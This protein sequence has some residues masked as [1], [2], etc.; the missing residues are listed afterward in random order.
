MA[1]QQVRPI[2][3]HRHENAARNIDNIH[4]WTDALRSGMF[5]QGFRSLMP[6]PNTFCCLGLGSKLAGCEVVKHGDMFSIGGE[7]SMPPKEFG[8]WL[9]IPNPRG[10]DAHYY[11]DVRVGFAHDWTD[12]YGVRRKVGSLSSSVSDL[13]DNGMSFNEIADLIDQLGVYQ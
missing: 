8:E 9:G 1:L 6:A 12:K 4:R 7:V 5:N 13:N 2:I 3:R 11:L 10:P